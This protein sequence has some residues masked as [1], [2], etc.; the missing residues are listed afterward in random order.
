MPRPACLPFTIISVPF[1]SPVPAG[2]LR[3]RV[4]TDSA[5]RTDTVLA[6]TD[7]GSLVVSVRGMPVA[8]DDTLSM[9]APAAGWVADEGCLAVGELNVGAVP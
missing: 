1:P 7:L 6:A 4:A 9:Y 3:L 2:G 8:V 5:G